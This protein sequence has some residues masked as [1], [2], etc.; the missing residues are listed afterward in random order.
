MSIRVNLLMADE[1]RQSSTTKL[2]ISPRAMVMAGVG[3]FVVLLAMG[4]AKFLHVTRGL[5]MAEDR[6]SEIAVEYDELTKVE[7]DLH[8]NQVIEGELIG[9]DN[10]SVAWN[11]PLTQLASL[12]PRDIQL[13][14]MTVKCDVLLPRI[15]PTKLGA[16]P[17]PSRQYHIRLDGLANGEFSDKTAV[18]FVKTLKTEPAF[19]GWLESVQLRGL[20]KSTSRRSEDPNERIFRVDMVSV[21]REMK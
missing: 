6:W 21:A 3:V 16:P 13:T 2:D 20:Q 8:A 15:D 10:S 14:K 11:E 18:D 9:W 19:E 5:A 12:V 7:E 4:A 17:A 1:F